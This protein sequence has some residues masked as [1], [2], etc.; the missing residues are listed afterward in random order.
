MINEIDELMRLRIGDKVSI[1]PRGKRKIWTAEFFHGG[2]HR[3]RSL[4]TANQKIAR[5]RAMILEAELA[6]GD[7]AAPVKPTGITDAI[8]EFMAA[9]KSEGRAH[10]TLVKYRDELDAFEV[11]LA[12][13]SI[14][15]LQLLTARAFDAYRGERQI[16]R[17]AKTVYTGLVIVKTFIKWAVNR[18]LLPRNPLSVCKV[19]TPYVPPKSSATLEQVDQILQQATGTR[20]TQYALLGFSG[21]R[22]GELQNLRRQDVDLAGNW[23]HIRAHGDWQPKTRQARKIPIHPRLAQI[24][25]PLRESGGPYFFC[26]APSPKYP[27]GDH[28]INIIRLNQDF[29]ELA[30]GLGMNVGRKSDGL[31]IHTLRHFFETQAVDSGI[32]QFMTDVW[33]GHVGHSTTGRL[34]YGLTDEKSQQYMKQV[35]F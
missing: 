11:F 5:Q 6:G 1:I 24:L 9:K 15:T 31:V 26:A 34:Y 12:A 25:S 35:K 19:T 30:K 4:K 21:I 33:M 7:Y 8:N 3:H 18:E 28:C 23:I 13:R 17:S 14:H 32:P 10:K 16:G 2:Q 22:A 20:K 29:Q 27:E